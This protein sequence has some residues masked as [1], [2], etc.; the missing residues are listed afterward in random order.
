MTLN[1][2][3]IFLFST[4]QVRI[5]VTLC[6]KQST[7]CLTAKLP[8]NDDDDDDDDYDDDDDDDNYGADTITM[9]MTMMFLGGFLPL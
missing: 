2:I 4:E 6:N 5:S 1:N 9:M 7:L 3:S 8:D